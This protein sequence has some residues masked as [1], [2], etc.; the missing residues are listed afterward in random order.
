MFKHIIELRDEELRMENLKLS[1]DN[2]NKTKSRV[3]IVQPLLVDSYS[4]NATSS[5][6]R[7]PTV[8]SNNATKLRVIAAANNKTKLPS[9]TEKNGDKNVTA[10]EFF[11]P[12]TKRTPH[13]D[14]QLLHNQRQ[15]GPFENAVFFLNMISYITYFIA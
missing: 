6:S 8:R 2:P 15:R 1:D 4:P 9:S 10:G 7:L 12:T 14:F 5:S 11:V 3:Q 13:G